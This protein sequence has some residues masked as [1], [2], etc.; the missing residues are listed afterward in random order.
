MY[1]LVGKGFITMNSNSF[2][3]S[4]PLTF[5]MFDMF[6]NMA[7]GQNNP[8]TQ[9]VHVNK[10]Y[11][12]GAEK[13]YTVEY[14]AP[15]AQPII[16]TLLDSNQQIA[17]NWVKQVSRADKYV[18]LKSIQV[19]MN[20]LLT[21]SGKITTNTQLLELGL[22]MISH[23]YPEDIIPFILEEVELEAKSAQLTSGDDDYD[24]YCR[25]EACC[26]QDY[27]IDWD[28]VECD[29]DWDGGPTVLSGR[30]GSIEWEL[31]AG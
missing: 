30:P 31:T 23:D 13:N 19:V 4:A 24:T 1:N 11:S 26:P 12:Y 8:I 29:D 25:C 21:T 27:R 16:P 7:V 22:P 28:D 2:V 14:V 5:T 9:M 20:G 17:V 18:S 6:M 10:S 15:K 3:S